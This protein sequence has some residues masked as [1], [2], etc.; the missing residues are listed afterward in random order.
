MHSGQPS[1]LGQVGQVA[2]DG[3]QG[4]AEMRGKP[5]DR[6]L[7]LA[8]RDVEYLGMPECLRHI[9]FFRL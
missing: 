9:R 8:A 6:D 5:F 2:A 7:A 3:L 1:G 4:D